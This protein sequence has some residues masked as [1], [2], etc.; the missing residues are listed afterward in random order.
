LPAIAARP[1][2][3]DGAGV[4]GGALSVAGLFVDDWDPPPQA[5]SPA[6]H[7]AKKSPRNE[8]EFVRRLNILGVNLSISR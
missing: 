3:E 6:R 4:A 7:A 5:A 8:F 1:D 2:G